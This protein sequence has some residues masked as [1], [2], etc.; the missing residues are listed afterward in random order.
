M[1]HE[2]IARE[3]AQ[4]QK[5]ARVG[6][7][8][9]LQ[10]LRQYAQMHQDDAIRLSLANQAVND[11]K[12]MHSKAL[13]MLS[14][15]Q[16]PTVAQQVM[17]SIGG[18]GGAPMPPPGGPQGPMP[19]QGMPPQGMPP[20]PPPGMQMPPQAPPLGMQM[21]PP[22]PPAPQM[23]PPSGPSAAP[24]GIAGLPARNIQNM[25]DGGIAGYADADE[26]VGYADGG[27]IRMAVGG[28]DEDALRAQARSLGYPPEL[29]ESLIQQR[30]AAENA[31]QQRQLPYTS[32]ITSG[33]AVP[34]FTAQNF[35]EAMPMPTPIPN[36]R[37]TGE[38][39][40]IGPN[41]RNP[42]I[43]REQSPS[44]GVAPTRTNLG[45]ATD[46]LPDLRQLATDLEAGRIRA[47]PG[48]GVVPMMPGQGAFKDRAL[49]NRE[50]AETTAPAV[51]APPAQT[52]AD[53]QRLLSAGNA[54]AASRG[55]GAGV[56]AG[57]P[58]TLEI[59]KPLTV[60]EAQTRARQFFDTKEL[61]AQQDRIAEAARERQADT[62]SFARTNRPAAP[63]QELSKRLDTE[64]FNE[65]GEK[66]KA[67]GMA[68]MMAGFKMME[69]PYGGKGLGSFLRNVGA[70]ATVGA[71][72]LQQSNKE[73]KELAQKRLQLRTTIEAAQNAAERGDFDR[74]LVLRQR[75]DDLNTSMDQNKA[76]L[77]KYAFGLEGQAAIG[78]FD[79]AAQ[80]I[81]AAK[82]TQ[83][84]ADVQRDIAATNERGANARA[85]AQIQ[86]TK[87]AALFAAN[88][89]SAQ[90]KF[91]AELGG[92]LPGT[93]PNSTQI[94]RGVE[95]MSSVNDI[96]T[97][98]AAYEKQA[99]DHLKASATTGA[100]LPPMKDKQAWIK[101]FI[102]NKRAY[103]LFNQGIAGGI[104]T[105]STP[106]KAPLYGR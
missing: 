93:V 80:S 95:Y 23:P 36:P 71:K 30:R 41:D 83:F 22:M 2:N 106:G 100:V 104:P 79:Q 53:L 11:A 7:P 33:I 76:L 55:A 38:T 43:T 96:D 37:M 1:L 20:A 89:P 13:A 39:P 82:R 24:Q 10:M 17:Q 90:A 28:L 34:Q 84:S 72:E 85:N 40:A 3:E 91:Y 14:G 81:E 73:F 67:K 9:A 26:A 97:A 60:E 42:L 25:A 101:E 5:L 58:P 68:L 65:V 27:A 57:R 52:Y 8:Q 54:P 35:G 51:P 66:E 69:S 98:L 18:Q 48:G 15:Q 105:T 50:P 86:A 87:E 29:T 46:R 49:G 75:G 16:P 99:L 77:A 59:P 47:V 63:F 64:E 44:S 70:G 56:G 102:E 4:L 45:N 94:R 103:S 32:A 12:D 21:P 88:L 78:A 61:N 92:A 31:P 6:S 19:P 74:E 62:L